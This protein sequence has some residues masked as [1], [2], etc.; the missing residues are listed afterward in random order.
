MN[1]MKRTDMVHQWLSQNGK[2]TGR[3]IRVGTGFPRR[4]VYAALK[5]LKES[6]K[7]MSRPSLRDTRLTY[8]WTV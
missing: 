7:V 2:K 5:D 8:Y 6:G 3:D 1:E 4:T